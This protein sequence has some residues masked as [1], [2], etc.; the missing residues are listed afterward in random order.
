MVKPWFWR[1]SQEDVLNVLNF[2][3]QQFTGGSGQDVSWELNKV[4]FSLMLSTWEEGFQ[5]SAIII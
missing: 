5:R 1:A 3:L 2:F 4:I